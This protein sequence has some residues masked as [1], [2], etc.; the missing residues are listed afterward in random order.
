MKKQ[1]DLL[2]QAFIE[3]DVE[4]FERV[5]SEIDVEWT[6]SK[7]FEKKMNRL[8]NKQSYSRNS[9]QSCCKWVACFVL[10]FVIFSGI[11]LNV[12]AVRSP[13]FDFLLDIYD[14]F[15][16]IFIVDNDVA[17]DPRYTDLE[18]S[19]SV[20]PNGYVI[21]LKNKYDSCTQTIYENKDGLQIT[22]I[23]QTPQKGHLMV[24]TEGSYLREVLIV[25]QTGQCFENKGLICISWKMDD[26][27]FF[28]SVPD[29]FTV[30]E[31]IKIAESVSPQ[32]K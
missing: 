29:C 16:A 3:A 27:V 20:L 22:L 7:R 2:R 8:R 10:V 17:S 25:G 19:P 28:L 5:T 21:K 4:Y 1:N 9:W 15:S 24:D 12:E 23:Q 14:K 6:P 26:Y 31:A 32:Y 11:A 13:I 18:Y 30:E